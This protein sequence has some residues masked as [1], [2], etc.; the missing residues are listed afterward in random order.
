[1]FSIGRRL[2]IEFVFVRRGRNVLQIR[3]V[4]E[5]RP[6]VPI[7]VSVGLEKDSSGGRVRRLRDQSGVLGDAESEGAAKHE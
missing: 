5:H 4:G 1:M 2:W 7:R 6:E 3:T